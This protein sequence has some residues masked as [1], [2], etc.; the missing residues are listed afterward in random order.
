MAT[1]LN[2]RVTWRLAIPVVIDLFLVAVSVA[3]SAFLVFGA[4][5]RVQVTHPAV[6]LKLFLVAAVFPFAMYLADVYETR[7]SEDLRGLLVR[8]M[9]SLGV[10]ALAFAA[11]YAL[12]PGLIVGRGV[13]VLA[14]GFILGLVPLWRTAF[15]QVAAHFAPGERILFIGT[16]PAAITLARELRERQRELGVEVVG[17]LDAER[18]GVRHAGIIGELSEITDIV[19]RH[20]VDRVIVSVEDARG[21]L[22][23]AEFLDLKLRGVRFDH[24]ASVYEEFTGRIAVEN[25]RPS[26]LVF[27]DGFREPKALMVTKR[28]VDVLVSGIALTVAA[29]IMLIVAAAVRLTSAGPVFYHQVR[30]GARGRNFTVHKFRTMRADAEKLSGPVFASERDPRVTPIGE[31]LRRTR[32]DEL[33]QLWNILSGEMSLV[34]PRPE[35]PEFVKDLTKQIPFYGQR[36]VVKPG[37]TGWAQVRNGYT[38][39]LAGTIEKLQYDLFY[40]KNM[41]IVLDLVIM[42]ST[43]KTVLRRQGSR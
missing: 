5:F 28:L 8:L 10:T 11:I 13:F 4:E 32:L 9:Q 20:H 42:F 43:V 17:F 37:L 22:P 23:M 21:T 6:L 33:P 39:D 1:V 41:S 27:S 24:L 30:V 29:P 25:L 12:I 2:Q 26:W 18:S 16:K 36:H 34:G 14:V 19:E 7:A 3:V 40:I 31:F 35:R 38:S 15:D